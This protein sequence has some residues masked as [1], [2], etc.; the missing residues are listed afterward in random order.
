[1][2][3]VE[4]REDVNAG[5]YQFFDIEI[6]LRMATAGGV[7]MSELVDEHQLRAAPQDPVEIHLR[8]QM[9]FVLDLLSRNHLEAFEER[10]G[11]APAMRFDDTNDNVDPVAQPGLRRQQHLV[12]LAD[13]GRG[14]EKNLQ[15]PA[16]LLFC[17]GEQCFG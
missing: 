17:R 5:Y 9:P 10:L 12:G 6:A 16:T 15:P 7:G 4:R 14:A 2:L 13:P 11:L 3:N 1:M 8:Q